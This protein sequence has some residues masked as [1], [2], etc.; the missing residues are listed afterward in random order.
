VRTPESARV[1]PGGLAVQRLRQR[2]QQADISILVVNENG[3][4]VHRYEQFNFFGTFLFD[5]GAYLQPSSAAS[6]AFALGPAGGQLHPCSC[7]AD[8]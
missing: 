6:R 4:V 7:R 5:I 3:N 2:A 1:Q 8:R